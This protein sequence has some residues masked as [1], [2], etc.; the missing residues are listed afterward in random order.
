MSVP[1]WG[2]CTIVLQDFSWGKLV[3]GALD[4]SVLFLTNGAESKII[5]K[6]QVYLIKIV[7]FAIYQQQIN[8]ILNLKIIFTMSITFNTLKYHVKLVQI[9]YR[10][11]YETL[12]GK[13]T[14]TQMNEGIYQVCGLEDSI[15]PRNHFFQICL[16]I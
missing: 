7:A 9:I 10:E 15:F 4:L 16:W 14:K 6:S 11:N 8:K 12:Q 3:K 1:W 13:W 5:S 2:Y